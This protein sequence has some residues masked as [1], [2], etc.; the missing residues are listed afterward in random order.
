MEMKTIA[1]RLLELRQEHNLS[2]KELSEQLHISRSSYSYY[3]SGSRTPDIYMLSEIAGYYHITI[4]ELVTGLPSRD[5]AKNPLHSEDIPVSQLL[6]HLKSKHI[7]PEDIFSLTKADFDF[8]KNYKKLTS[9][10]QSELQYLMNYKIK[11]QKT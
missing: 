1:L 10:N 4:D 6:H 7:A 2:Q 5:S 3:E 11:K 9:E 8:L